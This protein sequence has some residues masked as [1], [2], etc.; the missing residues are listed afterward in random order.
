MAGSNKILKKGQL[1]FKAGDKSDGM[2]LIR[3]GE[4]CVYLEQDGKEVVLATINEGGMVGEMAL[5]DNQPRSASV[6]AAKDAEVTLISTEDFAKLMKQIPKWFVGLMSALS[7]RLRQ[8]NERLKNLESSVGK[9]TPSA[10]T[11]QPGGTSTKPFQTP[12]R[13]LHI[14]AL[15]WN[16]DGEKDGKDWILGKLAT[17]KQ[18][19]DIFGEDPESVKRILELLVKEKMVMTRQD[20]YKNVALALQNR[21]QLSSLANFMLQFTKLSPKRPY[22]T[23][24]QLAMIRSLD[25]LVQSS[26]YDTVTVTLQDLQKQAQKQGI[27]CATWGEDIKIFGSLGDD[28]KLVKSSSGPGLRTNKKDCGAT[29]KNHELMLAFADAKLV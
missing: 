1:V 24:A 17:E 20:S 4:L 10:S 14:L 28:I 23:H 9:G 25:Q 6:R 21:G 18:L 8:T 7:T 13:V 27:D 15:L 12:I 3:K 26:P 16:K 5:F 22:L 19:A 2:Y 29:V 11:A